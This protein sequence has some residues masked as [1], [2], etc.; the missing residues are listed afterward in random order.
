MSGEM[1]SRAARGDADTSA[2]QSDPAAISY[3]KEQQWTNEFATA[4]V[5][6]ADVRM[7]VR[8]PATVHPLPGGEAIVAAPAAGRLQADVLLSIGDRVRSGQVLA[9]LEPRLATGAD[10]ATL[11][12][13]VAEA[14]A[15]LEAA[16][17]RR[18]IAAFAVG[19]A[20]CGLFQHLMQHRRSLAL[21]G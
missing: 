10:R 17:A 12:A 11:A 2:E 16:R 4:L 15:A 8:A 6:E 20:C 19:E 7:S 9:Y 5:A 13:D 18:R 1:P 14:R 21:G 3:L